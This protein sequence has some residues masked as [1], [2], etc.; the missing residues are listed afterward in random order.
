MYIKQLNFRICIKIAYYKCI[1]FTKYFIIVLKPFVMLQNIP[2]KYINNAPLKHIMPFIINA[3]FTKSIVMGWSVFIL[4]II[5]KTSLLYNF[6]KTSFS[7]CAVTLFT[8]I[9]VKG[10]V[11]FSIIALCEC[12]RLLPWG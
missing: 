6:D 7:H 10:K 5:L 11:H 2:A 1:E 8:V 4:K 3:L 9:V 12:I